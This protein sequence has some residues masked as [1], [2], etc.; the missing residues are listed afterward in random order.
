MRK[1]ATNVTYD[2]MR[3]QV[4]I[5][6]RDHAVVLPLQDAVNLGW[7][8]VELLRPTQQCDEAV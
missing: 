2:A 7:Q 4:T 3:R 1:Q 6:F 8:L 5:H